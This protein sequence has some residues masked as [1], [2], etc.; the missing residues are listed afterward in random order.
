MKRTLLLIALIIACVVSPGS[1]F[2]QK[3]GPS[4]AAERARAVEIATLLENDPL[5]KNAKALS[6]EFLVWLIEIPDITVTICTGMLGDYSKIK[7]DYAGTITTQLSFAETK[8][9]IEHPEEAKDEY[10]V[11]LA[12]VE[13]ALR[14]Y[15][16]IKKAKPRVRLEPLEELLVKQQ[17]GQLPEFI[18]NAMP[19][20][21]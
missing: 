15:Q 11:Y 1:S 19:G 18:R 16:N 6:R 21:K 8:F 20:C 17:A 14:T 7:G 9:V 4:T 13:S 2:A 12:G 5:N 3:R 10:R